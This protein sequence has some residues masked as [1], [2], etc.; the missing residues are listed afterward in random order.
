MSVT[1]QEAAQ[2]R[3]DAA[4]KNVG[5]ARGA[6]PGGV[7]QRRAA[8]A[9]AQMRA[10]EVQ[11]DGK[12]FLRLTGMASVY[13]QAYEMWDWAGPYEEVVAEGAGSASLAQDPDVVF[14]LNHTG[15]PF[16]RTGSGTLDLSEPGGGLLSEAYLNPKR[17]DVQDLVA[18][19]EDGSTT[20]MSFAFR[21]TEGSWS[22]DFSLYRIKSYSLD[23][24]D[25]SVVTYGA[26]PHTSV[27]ARAS[28]FAL[29]NEVLRAARSFDV[30]QLTLLREAIGAVPEHAE[31]VDPA[32]LGARAVA[33]LR[34]LRASVEQG[35]V[36]DPL[37]RAS[38][39]GVLDDLIDGTGLL[40]SGDGPLAVLL[41]L[42]GEHSQP[43]ALSFR[44]LSLDFVER[45]IASTA[46]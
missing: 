8:P 18:S 42:R 43:T 44:T 5:Q 22:P 25:T 34:L 16:A 26:N 36:S 4:G 27:E 3:A 20:E 9:S 12:D 2:R 30:D 13:E 14:L 39:I 33:D 45:E 28:Q 32:K 6:S 35:D 7:T 19:V 38:L 21:I 40:R 37:A 15:I 1:M 11:R 10:A 46:V 23:R 29:T 17:Q 24:G 41:H 31:H